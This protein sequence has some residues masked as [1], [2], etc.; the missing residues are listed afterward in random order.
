MGASRRQSRGKIRKNVQARAE[1]L[2]GSKYM[3]SEDNHTSTHSLPR[4]MNLSS[5]VPMSPRAK[6]QT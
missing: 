5:I 1:R 6:R 4:L 3:Q 2:M